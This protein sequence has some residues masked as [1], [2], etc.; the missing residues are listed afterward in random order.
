[1]DFEIKTD[2]VTTKNN[3]VKEKKVIK[4]GLVEFIVFFVLLLMLFL[5]ASSMGIREYYRAEYRQA[6]NDSIMEDEKV[7]DYAKELPNFV[8]ELRFAT[9]N[10]EVNNIMNLAILNTFTKSS[11]EIDGTWKKISTGT[12]ISKAVEIGTETGD[13]VE[14]QDGDVVEFRIYNGD[15]CSILDENHESVNEES[16]NVLED[17]NFIK[18]ELELCNLY[19]L[20][21]P[22]AYNIVVESN[23]NNY[24][25]TGISS[26]YNSTEEYTI[27]KSTNKLLKA[28]IKNGAVDV[29]AEVDF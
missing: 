8:E 21:M 16:D 7:I 6:T 3:G 17:A 4:M 22:E 14:S 12:T 25:V 19:M 1:M 24:I 29:S 10:E 26:Q 18:N 5:L 13:V 20:T 9:S 15:S 28:K 27:S 2:E 23:G 11:V